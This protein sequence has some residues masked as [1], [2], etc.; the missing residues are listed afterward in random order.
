MTNQLD[1][2]SLADFRAALSVVSV[3]VL[4]S[5]APLTAH[6]EESTSQI[7]PPNDRL[8]VQ[9]EGDLKLTTAV[10]SA[11]EAQD[12]FGVNLYSKNV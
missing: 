4:L 12:I 6:S 8:H 7:Q 10:P 3:T 2:N 11:D 5:I 9:T 1:R